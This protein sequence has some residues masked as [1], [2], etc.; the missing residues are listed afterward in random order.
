VNTQ[1]H[2]FQFDEEML[3]PTAK[4]AHRLAH[5]SP[6]VEFRAALRTLDR[7]PDEDSGLLAKN[8]DGRAFGHDDSLGGTISL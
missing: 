1:R 2:V 7:L 3:S 6:L 4:R 5:Q 8:D